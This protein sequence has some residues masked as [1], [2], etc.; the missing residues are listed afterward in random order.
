MPATKPR[1]HKATGSRKGHKPFLT[2][3]A[4]RKPFFGSVSKELP[5]LRLANGDFKSRDFRELVIPLSWQTQRN[6]WK[7]GGRPLGSGGATVLQR[8]IKTALE[9]YL[10]NGLEPGPADFVIGSRVPYQDAKCFADPFGTPRPIY[11]D[12]QDLWYHDLLAFLRRCGKGQSYPAK[13]ARCTACELYFLNPGGARQTTCGASKCKD[14][15]Y[16]DKAGRPAYQ[17]RRQRAKR[18]KRRITTRSRRPSLS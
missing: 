9:N 4:W 5:L 14:K 13:L 11:E 12:L 15:R 3:R 1:S 6:A 18:S 10:K 2:L 7:L 17:Q 8:C 16:Y